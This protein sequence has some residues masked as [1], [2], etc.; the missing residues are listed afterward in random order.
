MRH[1]SLSPRRLPRLAGLPAWFTIPSAV[2]KPLAFL[3][4]DFII[5]S[6]YRTQFAFRVLS[7][8]TS[9]VAFYFMARAF[10][11]AVAGHLRPYGGDYFGFA[12]IGLAFYPLIAT[13]LSSFGEAIME[14][15]A[16]GTLEAMLLT[17]TSLSTM[18][19]GSALWGLLTGGLS[20]LSYL[21]FGSVV[22]GVP[23]NW[24]SLPT[25]LVVLVLA[26]AATSGIGMLNAAVVVLVKRGT[27][28]IWAYGA[29][30]SVL[31]GMLYP[32][33]VLPEWLQPLSHLLPVTYALDGMRQALLSG[34]SLAEI[35]HDVVALCLFIVVLVPAGMASFAW[36]VR[37]AKID[38][39][40]NQF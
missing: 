38:G 34:R 37:R 26:M 33:S 39:S 18:L 11:S 27:P 8:V 32:I 35:W 6:S 21:A 9:V 2:A 16:S 3:K 28:T 31:G 12:L 7:G 14:E 17:P 29:A 23:L 40:L 30:A 19:V 4:R 1:W 24:A 15:Q 36:A 10:G 22:F 13:S 25:A 5:H 20:L